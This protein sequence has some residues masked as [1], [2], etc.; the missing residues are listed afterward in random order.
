MLLEAGEK[1]VTSSPV[2]LRPASPIAQAT[3]D[4]QE[5]PRARN[6][7]LRGQTVCHVL[8]VLFGEGQSSHGATQNHMTPG[9]LSLQRTQI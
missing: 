5:I 2:P 1:A 8:F 6:W 7:R 3:S 4:L 9:Q